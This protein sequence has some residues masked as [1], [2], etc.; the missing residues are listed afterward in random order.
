MQAI[1]QGIG[2]HGRATADSK[3]DPRVDVLRG[4]ALAMIFIDH[5]PGDILNN[6]TLRN[7]GFCDAA[8]IFVLLAGFASMSAYGK[9][10]EREGARSGLRRV[11]LRC[12]RLW[13]FQVGLLVPFFAGL[14]LS[15]ERF[16]RVEKIAYEL[17]HPADPFVAKPVYLLLQ[18]RHQLLLVLPPILVL[19]MPKPACNKSSRSLYPDRRLKFW[20][21][22]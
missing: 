15:W 19:L 3:R 12:V 16:Y 5:I 7:F 18:I 6:W 1:M 10:F 9:C 4:I 17:N 2:A 20:R 21:A 13:V 11:G 8:E 14:L 22:R